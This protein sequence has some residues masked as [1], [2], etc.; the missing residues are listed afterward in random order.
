MTQVQ[1]GLHHRLKFDLENGQVLDGPRRYLVM[2]PD[3][4]MGAFDH[5]ASE[6]RQKALEALGYAVTRFGGQSVQA[7]LQEVGVDALLKT[8]VNNSAS[9]GWGCWTFET[10]NDQLA[11]KVRNSPFAKSTQLKEMPVCYAIAGMFR[12]VVEAIEGQAYKVRE[13]RCACQHAEPNA[14]CHFVAEKREVS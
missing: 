12:A 1:Q 4:L 9:L 13:I 6:E 7:Y 3:V 14:W 10:I 11:L 2:R 5:L 8:M